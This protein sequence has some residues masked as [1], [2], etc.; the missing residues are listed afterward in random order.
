MLWDYF[1]LGIKAVTALFHV[2][3]MAWVFHTVLISLQRSFSNLGQ[4]LY[5]LQGMQLEL[6][7]DAAPAHS[8]TCLTWDHFSGEMSNGVDGSLWWGMCPSGPRGVWLSLSWLLMWSSISC[9]VNLWV[10]ELLFS[11]KLWAC[12]KG[13]L[14]WFSFSSYWLTLL[15]A[16]VSSSGSH[17]SQVF[18]AFN[19]GTSLGSGAAVGM[20]PYCYLQLALGSQFPQKV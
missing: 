8:T 20:S 17:P 5:T 18:R 14:C 15:P 1:S 10:P 6:G 4:L 9:S 12:L 13:S 3:G 16:A 11:R 7:D 2:D 19:P